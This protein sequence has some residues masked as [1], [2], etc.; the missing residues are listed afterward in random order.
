MSENNVTKRDL[1]WA[2]FITM[3]ML[4]LVTLGLGFPL[5]HAYHRI[6]ELNA[7]LSNLEHLASEMIAKER[8]KN[9]GGHLP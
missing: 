5:F 6:N 3:M 1:E 9:T 2:K 7:R 4:L 8:Q